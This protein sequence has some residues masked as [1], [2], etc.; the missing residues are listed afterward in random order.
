MFDQMLEDQFAACQAFGE[1]DSA[2]QKNDYFYFNNENNQ[3]HRFRRK[4]E[5]I[6]SLQSDA[7]GNTSLVFPNANVNFKR[8]SETSFS[9]N[10]TLWIKAYELGSKKNVTCIKVEES[11]PRLL[12]LKNAQKKRAH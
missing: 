11:D 1:K 10:Y 9:I 6:S 5:N 7:D 8:E 12:D 2:T 4:V 3:L